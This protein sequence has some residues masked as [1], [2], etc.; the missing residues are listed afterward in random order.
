MSPIVIL[1]AGPVGRATAAE[2]VRRGHA[3]TLVSRSLPATLPGGVH[4]AAGDVLD[5]AFMDEVLAGADVVIQALGLPY[6]R[7][8]SDWPPL[9][10]GVLDACERAGVRLVSFENLYMYGAPDGPMEEDAPFRPCSDKG[11]VRADLALDVL[12]RREAGTLRASQV[13]ASDLFGPTVHQSALGDEVFGR[14]ARGRAPR[15]LG[16][17]DA[18]HSWTFLDDAAV[19]LATVAAHPDPPPVVHVPSEPPCSSREIVQA[20]AALTGH[21]P[22]L[23]TT[24]RWLLGVVGWFDGTVREL[25]E[26]LYEFEAPFVLS[27][28]VAREQL[29]LTS[30]PLEDALA[31]TLDSFGIARI[32]AA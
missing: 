14:L 31:R 5:R 24:P 32:A 21:A 17:P 30:T 6:P 1:G 26:M 29:G 8:V 4:H 19:T 15:V 22:R 16:D 9:H 20:L 23:T 13:R 2:L 11:R 10:A 7:W 28:R 3:V 27:D 25:P 12:R 18:P